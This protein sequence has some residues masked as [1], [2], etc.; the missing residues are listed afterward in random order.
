MPFAHIIARLANLW[1]DHA[2]FPTRFKMVQVTPLIKKYGLDKNHPANYGP[3]SNL[4]VV[5]KF[6]E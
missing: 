4:N 3:I 2:T 6:L 1:F 5:I